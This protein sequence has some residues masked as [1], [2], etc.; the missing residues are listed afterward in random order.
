MINNSLP[1][2]QAILH[3]QNYHIV[4]LLEKHLKLSTNEIEE[5]AG[6][7]AKQAYTGLAELKDK[8]A[9]QIPLL[10][11]TSLNN[12][13]YLFFRKVTTKHCHFIVHYSTH[14]YMHL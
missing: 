9:Y 4:L 11:A 8:N 10:L 6:L 7:S 3:N 1:T 2:L 12:L 14:L 13:E 5:Y